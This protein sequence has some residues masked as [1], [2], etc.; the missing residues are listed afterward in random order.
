MEDLME[1]QAFKLYFSVMAKNVQQN[2]W[3]VKGY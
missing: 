3:W 1:F 2:L